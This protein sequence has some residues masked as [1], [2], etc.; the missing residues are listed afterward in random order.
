MLDLNL[1][2]EW[3]FWRNVRVEPTTLSC[4]SYRRRVRLT[5][6][7]VALAAVVALWAIIKI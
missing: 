5:E 6:W 2:G 4:A 3:L 1:I 7:A